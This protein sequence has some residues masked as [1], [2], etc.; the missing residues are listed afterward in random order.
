MSRRFGVPRKVRPAYQRRSRATLD[1]ILDATLALLDGRDFED[2]PV[3]EITAAAEISPSSL[4]ARFPTKASLLQALHERHLA[5][6]KAV[7][8]AF[9]R[10]EHEQPRACADVIPALIRLFLD[11]QEGHDGPS[12]TFR[13][14][15]AHDP[16]FARRRREL[17]AY[18]IRLVRDYLLES[19]DRAAQPRDTKRVDLAVWI[20]GTG[21]I[22][23]VQPPHRFA[24]VIDV[25]RDEMVRELQ[26]MLSAYLGLPASPPVHP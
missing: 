25:S 22:A 24:D 5:R 3:L 1:R 23:A 14:A 4:Y 13:L 15:E 12:R 21:M 11:F 20:L 10:G 9:A 26:A 17:D 19:C 16:G 18:A 8:D 2:V 7:I 6:A